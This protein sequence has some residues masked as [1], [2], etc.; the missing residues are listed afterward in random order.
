MGTKR[1]IRLQDRSPPGRPLGAIAFGTKTIVD[2]NRVLK[3]GQFE[4]K[5]EQSLDPVEFNMQA[6]L[7]VEREHA[8]PG[9]DV[10]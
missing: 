5:H 1:G 2:A 3:Y 7:A 6:A 10:P 4:L 9:L 8:A